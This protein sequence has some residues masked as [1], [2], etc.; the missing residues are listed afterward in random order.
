MPYL[1][2]CSYLSIKIYIEGTHYMGL[3][4]VLLLRTLT[5]VLLNPDIH[6]LC[7]HVDQD[8]LA[9]EVAN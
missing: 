1:E 3:R 6:C 8:Q 7:K 2:L 4:E 5:L 9:S